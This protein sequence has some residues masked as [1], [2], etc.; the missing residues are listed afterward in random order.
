MT[1]DRWIGLLL[2]GPVAVAGVFSLARLA[3]A[4]AHVPQAV[5]FETVARALHEQNIDS[6]VDAVAV[7]PPWSLR[8][9][10]YLR[11]MSPISGDALAQQP[12]D[13]YRR[14]FVVI[15]P[16]AERYVRPLVSRL[17]PPSLAARAG[18]V[19]LAR[20]DLPQRTVRF[21]FRR[22]I[23]TGEVRIADARTGATRLACE[24]RIL[25]G[26]GCGGRP[27][28]QRV[29]REWL[30]VTDNGEEA[31]WI[32]PPPFGERLEIAFTAVPL[33][34]RTILRAGYTVVGADRATVPLRVSMLI[35][36]VEAWQRRY[37]PS[38]GFG[39]VEI[40]T[41]RWSAAPHRVT[42]LIESEGPNR[43][44]HFAFDGYTADP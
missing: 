44:Q 21:D 1:S 39:S 5:D 42:F 40:D 24:H 15:E 37:R 7:L 10:E 16:D 28:W 12:L 13:R 27:W 19:E 32:H 31:I 43:Y 20:F 26:V 17:G 29:D 35:D 25:N 18:V 14:L 30:H 11:G 8:P 4:G 6:T 33:G 41:R 34:T 2:L 38:V 22:S 23:E 36:D 9:Y 3:A